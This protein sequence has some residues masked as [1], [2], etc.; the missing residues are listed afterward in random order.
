MGTR[1]LTAQAR[2][3]SGAGASIPANS[4]GGRPFLL[5]GSQADHI[6]GKDHTWDGNWPN[7]SGWKRWLTMAHTDHTSF[8]DLSILQKEAGM[9]GPGNLSPQRSLEITRTY[10]GAFFDLHLKGKKQP[11]LSGPSPANP[12]IAFH[13]P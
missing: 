2:R 3:C 7:M 5:L 4:L 1:R 13:N 10:I 12:E 11:L 9:S 6:P 8:T